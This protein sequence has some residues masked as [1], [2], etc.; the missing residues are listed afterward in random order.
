MPVVTDWLG[1]AFATGGVFML[2]IV[3]V[4]GVLLPLTSVT[5]NWAI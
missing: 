2:V 1:P 5:I 3:T 4:A